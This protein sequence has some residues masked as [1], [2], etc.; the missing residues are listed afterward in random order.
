MKLVRAAYIV[1]FVAAALIVV[2]AIPNNFIRLPSAAISLM[3]GIGIV[4]GRVWSAYGYA[5]YQLA[6]LLAIPIILFRYGIP[7]LLFAL[8]FVAGAALAMAL[9]VLFVLAGRSLE[10]A[11][12]KRGLASPWIAVSALSSLPLIFVGAFVIPSA[13]MENTLLVGDPVLVRCLPRVTPSRGDIIVFRGAADRNEDFVK[14]VIGVPGDRIRISNKVVYRNGKPLQEPYAIHVTMY[15][16]SYRDN[17]PSVTNAPLPSQAVDML[18][19]HVVDG[20][21][22]VP[23]QNYFVLGDNRDDSLDSRYQGFVP[24]EDVRGRPLLIYDS[25]DRPVDLDGKPTEP[26]RRRWNRLFKLL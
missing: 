7:N 6:G 15:V 26:V 2:S 5:L 25:L 4:R 9:A 14:R 17:F 23:E 11:G 22:V 19:R 21:V 24:A 20:E 13:A 1:A 12:S 3:A 18:A 16:D 8:E 10:A